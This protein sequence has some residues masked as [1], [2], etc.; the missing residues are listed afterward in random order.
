M[1]TGVQSDAAFT[2]N[3]FILKLTWISDKEFVTN[4]IIEDI[5]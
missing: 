1:R 4:F 2:S 5:M 3:A